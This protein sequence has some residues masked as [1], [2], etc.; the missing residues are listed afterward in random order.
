MWADELSKIRAGLD[1]AVNAVQFSL[2][3][4]EHTSGFPS[5]S[6]AALHHVLRG[7]ELAKKYQ[8]I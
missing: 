3:A 7:S 1:P 8:N 6:L 2:T 5:P 4:H